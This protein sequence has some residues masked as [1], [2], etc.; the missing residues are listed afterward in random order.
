MLASRIFI[1]QHFTRLIPTEVLDVIPLFHPLWT[2][3]D[4]DDITYADQ[5]AAH[6]SAPVAR[7]RTGELLRWA[8]S[9][10]GG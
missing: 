1:W 9:R 5:H 7:P 2:E 6:G 10:L 8:F 3:A 4:P